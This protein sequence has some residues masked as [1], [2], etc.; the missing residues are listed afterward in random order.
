M[1]GGRVPLVAAPD[2]SV[3]SAFT[4]WTCPNENTVGTKAAT[5]GREHL[6]LHRPLQGGMI[7]RPLEGSA[8]KAGCWAKGYLY[9]ATQEY[10]TDPDLFPSISN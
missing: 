3:R 6:C 4:G 10:K 9:L 7:R 2:A 5:G 8:S 1:S